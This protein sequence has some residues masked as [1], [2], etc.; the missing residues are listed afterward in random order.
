MVVV[1]TRFLFVRVFFFC[2]YARG[3]LGNSNGK[4]V[5]SIHSVFMNDVFNLALLWEMSVLRRASGGVGYIQNT[6]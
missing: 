5:Y 2:L 3:C 6:T 1:V 4:T